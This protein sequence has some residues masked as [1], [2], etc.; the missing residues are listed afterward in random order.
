M[1]QPLHTHSVSWKALLPMAHFPY[2]WFQG[3]KDCQAGG[4]C[5]LWKVEY[6]HLVHQEGSKM[7]L[8]RRG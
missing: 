7:A 1:G 5:F 3:A 8:R 4:T 2:D 6:E